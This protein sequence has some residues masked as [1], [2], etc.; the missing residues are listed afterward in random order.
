MRFAAPV[1]MALAVAACSPN[2]LF[3]RGPQP[4]ANVEAQ[5]TRAL[6]LLEPGANSAA[7]DTASALLESYL[8]RAGYIARRPEAVALRR[9]AGDA[10]QLS[11]VAAALQQERAENR[12]KSDSAPAGRTDGDSLKEIQRLKD[13]LAAANAELERIK[14]RL[15]TQKP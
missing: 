9:L 8:A 5:F 7:L 12:T 13:E 1:L 14:K 11:K 6:T 2:R 4:D 15:A 3:Q 10:I